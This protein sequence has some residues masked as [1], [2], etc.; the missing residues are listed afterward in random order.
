MFSPTTDKV[1]NCPWKGCHKSFYVRCCFPTWWWSIGFQAIQ[2]VHQTRLPMP[3]CFIRWLVFVQVLRSFNC[4]GQVPL[5]CRKWEYSCQGHIWRSRLP[6]RFPW[7][8]PLE[9]FP[10][11]LYPNAS[12]N[13]GLW[14]VMGFSLFGHRVAPLTMSELNLTWNFALMLWTILHCFTSHLPC[15]DLTMSTAVH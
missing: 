15:A 5:H 13:V 4:W 8:T 12:T 11:I 7:K 2:T 9:T 1:G 14:C 3:C 10:Q 6:W